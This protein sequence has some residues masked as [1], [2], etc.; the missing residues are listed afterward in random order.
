MF[1]ASRRSGHRISAASIAM[2]TV[3][4]VGA[5]SLIWTAPVE[6]API[7]D[8]DSHLANI[9][10]T[11]NF[12]TPTSNLFFLLI[13]QDGSG[14]VIAKDTLRIPNVGVIPPNTPTTL[15]FQAPMPDVA[16]VLHIATIGMYGQGIGV[17][18]GYDPTAA[19]ADVANGTAW[20][21]IF[22]GLPEDQV[23]LFLTNNITEIPHGTEALLQSNRMF[24]VLTNLVKTS[25]DLNMDLINTTYSVAQYGGTTTL[26]I[27]D[28]PAPEP[29]PE[30]VTL[31][32]FGVGLGGT[33]AMR[34]HNSAKV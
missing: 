14:N 25:R 23:L 31:S 18:A 10:A 4:L 26:D 1:S 30:P 22:P 32:I 19:L 3:T 17:M 5:S 20:D 12:T 27:Q 2:L 15:S 29:V 13:A 28:P 33:V 34:R 8:P 24:T 16:S 11:F 6:A 9:I 21:T 7:L